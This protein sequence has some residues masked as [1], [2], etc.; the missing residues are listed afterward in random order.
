MEK[1]PE[2]DFPGPTAPERAKPDTAFTRLQKS[3]QQKVPPFS[4]RRSPNRPSPYSIACLRRTLRH[5]DS[6]KVLRCKPYTSEMCASRRVK[7]GHD[8]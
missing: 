4:R 6:D 2:P 8:E 7:P 5:I 1:A 3:L